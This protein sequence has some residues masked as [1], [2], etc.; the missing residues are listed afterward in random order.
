MIRKADLFIHDYQRKFSIFVKK[1]AK[2][3]LISISGTQK[4]DTL[5]IEPCDFLNIFLRFWPFE[6]HFLINFFL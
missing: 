5:E 6:P 2:N 1:L 3:D 4:R